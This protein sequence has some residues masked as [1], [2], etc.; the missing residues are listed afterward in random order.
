VARS[1]G[2]TEIAHRSGLGRQSPYKAVSREGRPEIE[3]VLKIVRALDLQRDDQVPIADRVPVALENQGISDMSLFN[4]GFVIFPE[5]T[6]LDF[7]GPLQ[8]LAR[9]PQSATH[10][11]AKSEAPVPS[12]CGSTVLPT[13]TFATCPPLDL[14]CI[15][16]GSS[17]V[18]GAMS[19][20]DTVESLRRRPA[21]RST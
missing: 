20:R 3:T 13:H 7:T 16:G 1:N 15:P 10:V 5:V 12:G 9:L 4:V 6:Q 8:V 21:R 14:I 18:V 19:D 17:G 2:I 11:V